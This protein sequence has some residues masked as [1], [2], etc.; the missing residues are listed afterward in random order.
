[1]DGDV[2]IVV[3]MKVWTPGLHG[4]RAKYL[5]SSQVMIP[6]HLPILKISERDRF[7]SVQLWQLTDLLNEISHELVAFS[8]TLSRLIWEEEIRSLSLA[9]MVADSFVTLRNRIQN[10]LNLEWNCRD[11]YKPRLLLAVNRD[12]SQYELEEAFHLING[13]SFSVSCR[14]TEMELYRKQSGDWLLREVI[15]M[16][17]SE[18]N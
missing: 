9:P 2:S 3:P 11:V 5:Q 18:E 17:E 8:Y 14:A 12:E 4:F 7:S 10:E 16:Q 1:M 6:P 13:D 15:P